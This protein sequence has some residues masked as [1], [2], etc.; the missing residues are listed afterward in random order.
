MSTPFP[1]D[2]PMQQFCGSKSD[3]PPHKKSQPQRSWQGGT[4]DWWYECPGWETTHWVTVTDSS[5]TETKRVAVD[6]RSEF[7][8]HFSDLY[9]AI[10]GDYQE[11]KRREPS[12][13]EL[14]ADLA[15][16]HASPEVCPYDSERCHE[17]L[18]E[19]RDRLEEEDE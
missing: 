13:T 16:G 1:E 11:G 15:I 18:W 9:C 19:V 5:G 17:H 4:E 12:Q 8:G 3:H 2:R 7:K 10:V 6:L 14:E